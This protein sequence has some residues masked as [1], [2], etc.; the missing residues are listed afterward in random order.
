MHNSSQVRSGLVWLLAGVAVTT[1]ATVGIF[2]EDIPGIQQLILW[3]NSFVGWWV[4]IAVFIAIVIEGL[5][6][7]GSFFPG[8]SIVLILAIITQSDSWLLFWMTIATIFVGWVL[9]SII[10]IYFA[11][12]YRI[13]TDIDFVVQDKLLLTW[14]PAFRAN[15]EVAQVVQGADPFKVFLSSV[16]VKLFGSILVTLALVVLAEGIDVNQMSNNEGFATLYVSAA[17]MTGIGMWQIRT[18]LKSRES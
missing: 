6:F 14:F 13:E 18:Y 15:Y 4:L 1:Y 12:R 11:K 5:Y 16:R 8:S 10:N 3:L 7:I 9:S 2:V 17:V